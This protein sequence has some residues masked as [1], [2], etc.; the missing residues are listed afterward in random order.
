MME[1][2]RVKIL[3][4][5]ISALLAIFS[6]LG[7]SQGVTYLNFFGTPVPDYAPDRVFKSVDYFNKKGID[8]IVKK[9]D[10]QDSINAEIRAVTKANEIRN[11]MLVGS[12]TLKPNLTHLRNSKKIGPNYYRLEVSNISPIEKQVGDDYCW[13]ACLQYFLLKEFQV[14]ATQEHIIGVTNK[15]KK[16]NGRPA[17]AFELLKGLGYAGFKL[18]EKGATHIIETLGRDH[19]IMLG[20]KNPSNEVG[21]AVILVA[22]TF[23]FVN[24]LLP[25]SDPTGLGIAFDNLVILDPAI[26]GGGQAINAQD[27]ENDLFFVLSRDVSST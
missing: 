3:I 8:L 6:I 26:G 25:N 23:A 19:I 4:R 13:A 1:V 2:D 22:A 5:F 11:K 18:T 14:I 21:H 16:T 15:L 10:M 27:I 17:T 20:I 7:C 9:H 12:G 24:D